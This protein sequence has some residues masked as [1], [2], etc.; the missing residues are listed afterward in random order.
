MERN[1]EILVA[2]AA[3][4]DRSGPHDNG[5]RAAGD[6][7][8]L[9]RRSSG[10][11]HVLDDQDALPAVKREPPSQHQ[12]TVLTFRKDRPHAEGPG[13]FLAD[14]DT[15]ERR[16]QNHLR[17]EISNALGDFTA[18]GVGLLGVLQHERA[19]EVA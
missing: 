10:G 8:R 12:A 1:V 6:V 2:S 7:D 3:V 14:D 4:D 11:H 15:A 16:R 5:T 18:A 9:A 13:H 17:S 19:L